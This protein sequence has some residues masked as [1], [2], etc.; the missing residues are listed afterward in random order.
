MRLLKNIV[1]LWIV[2]ECRRE[3]AR[4]NP[5]M[6]YATLT[7]LAAEA[8]PFVSLINPADPRFLSPEQ[9]PEKVS[10]FCRETGQPV[11]DSPGALV[12]AVLESLALLYRR[13]LDQIEELTGQPIARLH[14]VG[15][16]SR[17]QLL[18]QFTASALQRPV[19][20]GPV[21][22]TA[23]GNILIQA[24]TKGELP[25]LNEAREVVRQSYPLATVE[26]E[27]DALWRTA[28]ERFQRLCR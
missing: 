20:A 16:G 3:W 1:G 6:S 25:G 8:A 10:T 11:P 5:E 14:I 19:L 7:E 24:I 21:E 28:Y 18:N 27:D 13:T 17:N 2:Q 23:A 12:R 9:M 15:G 4:E 26:P 22:A